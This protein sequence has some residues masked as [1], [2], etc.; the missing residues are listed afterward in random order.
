MANRNIAIIEDEAVIR[1]NYSDYLQ[2]QGY[3]V[4]G[5]ASRQKAITAFE[6]GLPDLVI[7]DIGLEDDIDG[8]FELCRELR[9][10]SATLPII[11]LTARDSDFDTVAGLRLGAD[12]Y[13]TKEVSLPHLAARIAALFRRLEAMTQTLPE[14][15]CYICGALQLDIHQ[16]TVQWEETPVAL[17]VTEFWM[18]HALVKHPGHVRSRDQ[19]MEQ[20][21]IYVDEASIS[22]HIKRIRRKFQEIDPN[23]DHIESVYG[24]GYRWKY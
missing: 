13:L 8:G 21:K 14:A 4:S 7:L 17:T 10:R 18:I 20:A 16:L 6:T 22:S 23:F 19:L 5:Y 12:D 3:Q 1:D 15:K 2:R 9:T 11:F 24:A